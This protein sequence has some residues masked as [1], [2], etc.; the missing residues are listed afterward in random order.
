MNNPDSKEFI[1]E[2]GNWRGDQE[3]PMLGVNERVHPPIQADQPCTKCG[4]LFNANGCYA[5]GTCSDR[6]HYR[7]QRDDLARGAMDAMWALC[8]STRFASEKNLLAL[9][10]EIR[11]EPG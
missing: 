8:P 10:L 1:R 9:C 2:F 3:P 5:D 11:S 4:R 7:R 6:C